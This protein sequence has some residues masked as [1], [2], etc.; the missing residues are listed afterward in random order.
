[1]CDVHQFL[2]NVVHSLLYMHRTAHPHNVY[3][4]FNRQ[5]LM[6]KLGLQSIDEL[7]VALDSLEGIAPDG[8]E[9]ETS[10]IARE[11]RVREAYLN[12]CKEFN[13]TPDESRF[14][15]FSNNFLVME[16]Y[17]KESKKDM[18]LNQYADFTKE[19]YEALQ[20][21][22]PTSSSQKSETVEK[23]SLKASETVE[24]ARI[25]IEKALEKAAKAAIEAKAMATKSIE[26]LSDENVEGET[27]EEREARLKARAEAIAKAE[28]RAAEERTT[29]AQAVL[30]RAKQ[31]M[32]RRKE[33]EQQKA[34]REKEQSKEAEKLQ[35]EAEAIAIAAAR[36]EA[37]R[38]ATRTAQ[39][40]YFDAQAAQ[41]ARD[42]ARQWDEQQRKLKE[43]KSAVQKTKKPAPKSIYAS[44][45]QKK[46]APKMEDPKVE[47]ELDLSSIKLPT[48][49]SPGLAPVKEN[50]IAAFFSP[51]SQPLVKIAP[52]PAPA[53]KKAAAKDSTPAFS[54]FNSKPS[55]S[56]KKPVVA[57]KPPPAPA[58]KSSPSPAP[59]FSF[60][61]SP[62]TPK[63]KV[64]PAPL[65]LPV[66][67]A[68]APS[69]VYSFFS[70]P[71]PAKK[72]PV[73]APAPSPAVTAKSSPTFSIFGSPGPAKKEAA[74]KPKI[75]SKL[76]T[77][78]RPM[79]IFSP[80]TVPAK[81]V[82]VPSRAGSINIASATVGKKE[83]AKPVSTFSLFGS[84]SVQPKAAAVK[85]AKKEPKPAS[86][87]STFSLFGSPSPKK[88]ADT[89]V[90]NRSGSVNI[91][92]VT[93]AK[94]KAVKPASP[95]SLF[96]SQSVQP[97]AAAFPEPKKQSESV[98]R[99]PTFSLF[100]SPPKKAASEAK[101]PD[102]KVPNRAGTIG[103]PGAGTK[104]APKEE[105]KTAFSFFGGGASASSVKSSA[106][107]G[108]PVISQWQQNEDG[109]ITGKVSNS[110]GYRA[111]TEITTSPVSK[112]AKAG[113]VVKT[114]SGS[115]YYLS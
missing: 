40:A 65:P 109:S 33:I 82:K 61:L 92:G 95:F 25:G 18:T 66:A 67:K 28:K 89:K 6:E 64:A 112:G 30:E 48:F 26:G 86:R 54:F 27:D 108:V 44:I 103:I 104:K 42:K 8:G 58:A 88:V 32:E 7:E 69:S 106:P 77:E 68:A 22:A 81:D 14:P 113:T 62:T 105:A 96:G 101:K 102:I 75:D 55:Q 94:R 38:E 91:V 3:I 76:Q 21:G 20:S 78:L 17:A 39:R 19:E 37:E 74:Q 46:E 16:Q 1:M 49:G 90:P 80:K 107:A 79:S 111:G 70:A 24:K 57:P 5:K 73:S 115:L 110:K 47:V 12:W 2:V 71:N 10:N 85:E 15:T 93:G 4:N 23:V 97:K 63:T 31:E 9:L 34:E 13:K 50:A 83:A 52:K 29:R 114:G 72:K 59:A 100:G 56:E 84:Q 45:S 43:R 98:N 53:P 99:P 41:Q 36:A 87:S 60:F 51:K 11:A 35:K